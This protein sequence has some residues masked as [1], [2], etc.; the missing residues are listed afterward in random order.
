MIKE[1]TKPNLEALDKIIE[2]WV[3][4]STEMPYYN[5]EAVFVQE[6]IKL[7]KE[8]ANIKVT[9]EPT[10]EAPKTPWWAIW[11]RKG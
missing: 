7:L 8:K 10:V 4:H 6:M 3:E 5:K 9:P 2:Y 11:K 1:L